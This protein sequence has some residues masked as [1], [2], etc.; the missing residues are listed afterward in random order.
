MHAV[1]KL[2]LVALLLAYLVSG[3]AAGY[4]RT[5][6]DSS[7]GTRVFVDQLPDGTAFFFRLG[8]FSPPSK[9]VFSSTGM[10]QAQMNF[11]ATHY[12]G[13]Q[14]MTA[15]WATQIRQLNSNFIILHYQLA[16]GAGPVPFLVQVRNNVFAAYF[17]ISKL[18]TRS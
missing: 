5:F 1:R 15:D 9:R 10:S 16:V 3:T 4:A 12:V 17:L 6:A 8:V 2:A 14:K 7:L 18:F 11:T 13:T